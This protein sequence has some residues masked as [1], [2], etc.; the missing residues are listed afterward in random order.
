MTH[1]EWKAEAGRRFGENPQHWRFV[2]P[3]CDHVA[4]VEDWRKVE[5]PE[6]AVAV[7]CVGRWPSPMYNNHNAF[8]HNG[9]PCSY[10]GRGLISVN[11]VKVEM[12]DGTIRRV[13]AFAEAV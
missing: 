3:S 12:E 10:T 4:S 11:P 9:G 2:C 5:A 7:D 1:E 13:F 6:H 8:K